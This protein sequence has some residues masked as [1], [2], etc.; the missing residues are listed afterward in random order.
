MSDRPEP[1]PSSG[2]SA[3]RNP[4]SEIPPAG[5]LLGLD[6]GTK[7]V[8]V[9]VSDYEQ[10]YAAPLAAIAR[11]SAKGDAVALGRLVD[12]NAAVGLV[13]GLPVHMSGDEGGKA[14]QAREFGTWAGRATGLP[15][16]YWD[17]RHSSTIAE[18]RLLGTD[19]NGNTVDGPYVGVDTR[20]C[21]IRDTTGEH[22]VG[23]L[24]VEDLII[25]HTPAAT[26]VARKGDE[27]AVKRLI[28]QI[29]ERGLEW[30]L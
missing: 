6:F 12:E 15:V 30:Y 8:G 13:V 11:S 2:E 5:R 14:K 23:T 25:V 24:G 29:R 16:A 27:N 7:R 20:N 4:Q 10:R 18:G 21:T 9:A 17:E 28:D 19:E 1:R 3:I 22:L 26:L